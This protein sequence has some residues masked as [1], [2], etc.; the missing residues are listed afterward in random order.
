MDSHLCEVEGK[1]RPSVPPEVLEPRRRQ[2]GVAHRVLDVLVSHPC[3]DGPGIVAG[4]RQCIAAPMPKP[5]ANAWPSAIARHSVL[6]PLCFFT[7]SAGGQVLLEYKSIILVPW[8]FP[9][10]MSPRNRLVFTW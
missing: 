7:A 2:L 1:A 9:P 10:S 4:V 6:S 3:L 5:P 8:F